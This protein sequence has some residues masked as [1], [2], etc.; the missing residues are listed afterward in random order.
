M[1]ATYK[2]TIDWDDD[3]VYEAGEEVTG[4]LLTWLFGRQFSNRMARTAQV[5]RIVLTNPAN[6][7][8]P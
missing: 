3:G 4:D 1:A 8:L 5:G 2:L 7:V 6:L